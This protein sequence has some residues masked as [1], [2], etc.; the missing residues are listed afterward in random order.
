MWR[1]YAYMM[2]WCISVYWST[3]ILQIPKS[4]HLVSNIWMYPMQ[5]THLTSI[6][7]FT[8]VVQVSQK[9]HRLRNPFCKTCMVKK[10]H[11]PKKKIGSF[12]RWTHIISSS[13]VFHPSLLSRPASNWCCVRSPVGGS[14]FSKYNRTV[15][16]G[17]L[18]SP[19]LSDSPVSEVTFFSN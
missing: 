11:H 9:C 17:V 7:R 5:A 16:P 12:L 18:S 14:Y 1:N 13:P 6:I 15:A 3:T 8:I 4:H 19:P 2:L 10:V